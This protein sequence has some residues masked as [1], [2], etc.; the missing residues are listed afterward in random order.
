[1]RIAVL[2][3]VAI[4]L[5]ASIG[6]SITWLEFNGVN[7][8]FL[9]HARSTAPTKAATEEALPIAVVEGGRVFNFGVLNADQTREKTFVIRNEGGKPLDVQWVAES[10]GKCI[11]GRE[12][13]SGATVPPG[14]SCEVVVTYSTK[15]PGPK[16][17]ESATISTN[18]PEN[19]SLL[20]EIKGD[21]VKAVRLEPESL[22]LN[23]ILGSESSTAKVKL[24][25][26]QSDKL[27]LLKHEFNNPNANSQF[28]WTSRP[29]N[30]SELAAIEH[31]RA[32]LELQL[33][34][35]PGLPIGPISQNVTFKVQAENESTLELPITGSVVGDLSVIG[36]NI[37][38]RETT[39]SLGLV[40]RDTGRSGELFV[41]VKGP[42]RDDVKL[43]VGEVDPPELKIA[44][45]EPKSEGKTV[46]Y[47]ITVS[48]PKGTPPMS[49]IGTSQ[50]K[51]GRFV[52]QTTHP[53]SKELP[54]LVRFEVE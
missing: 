8:H 39:Y 1:M 21:V 51:A 3:I 30:A 25:G 5:G 32:G 44:V 50:G 29:L 47:P 54:I 22:T 42:Y 49:R 35:K 27:E 18:D 6:L 28:E 13:F 38:P 41:L 33:L 48:I 45:G 46:K 53:F 37:D 11:Q 19:S 52:L 36:R 9:Q 4:L 15:K 24:I 43:T 12:K 26:Y 10:C 20:L 40:K 16:F 7:E 14:G 2:S 34:V 31:A 17:S 23:S